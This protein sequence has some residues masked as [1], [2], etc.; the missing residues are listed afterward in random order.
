MK[1]L[2][3]IFGLLL[4]MAGPAYAEN[5][6]IILSEDNIAYHQLAQDIKNHIGNKALRTS[7]QIK[8]LD[9]ADSGNIVASDLI[10]SIG[11]TAV[12]FSQ[13]HYPQ[14]SHLYSFIDKTVIQGDDATNWVAVLMDQPLQRLFDTATGIVQGGL[15]NRLVIAV[16]EDNQLIRDEIAQL[17]IPLGIQ[18]DIVVVD[19]NAEPAKVIDSVLQNAGALI[20][21]RDSRVWSGEHAKWMLYQSYKYK[22]PVVGYSKSFL[23]AGALISVYASLFD[24]VRET[25]NLITY[26]H[27]YQG[28]KMQ[29][30]NFYPPYTI[31]INDNI[32]RA[33]EIHI[34]DSIRQGAATDVSD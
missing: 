13:R 4:V 31:S 12:Q 29:E 18:L 16:S 27:D 2:L 30:R 34:P 32:A 15:N 7:T 20:A 19:S 24:T 14:N 9:S 23:K 21:V 25:A 1:R 28:W 8:T 17:S 11:E 33:L 3:T 26:W 6:H 5:V 10:V 22:V